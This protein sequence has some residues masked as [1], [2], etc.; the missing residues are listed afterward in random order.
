MKI[1]ISST[2]DGMYTAQET[3][4]IIK[5]NLPEAYKG[6]FVDV[7]AH[8]SVG[9]Y[10]VSIDV[11]LLPKTPKPSELSVRNNGGRF[12]LQGFD[13]NGKAVDKSFLVEQVFGPRWTKTKMRKMGKPTVKEAVAHFLKYLKTISEPQEQK[14]GQAMGSVQVAVLA[15]AESAKDAEILPLNVY[16]IIS[17]VEK[18]TGSKLSLMSILKAV[19]ALNNKGLLVFDGDRKITKV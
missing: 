4:D 5:K 7:S 17:D 2:D 11:T 12:L 18:A 9:E 13:S 6:M 10:V 3:S 16:T 14:K 15:I 8:K 1:T 19:V